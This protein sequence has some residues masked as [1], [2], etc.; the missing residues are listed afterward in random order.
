MGVRHEKMHRARSGRVLG[1]FH[2]LPGTRD[3]GQAHSLLY[4]KLHT[5]G[6]HVVEK[7]KQESHTVK[8]ELLSK[9]KIPYGMGLFFNLK[10]Y[11]F[12]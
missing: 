3:K 12:T 7:V 11:V 8:T 9:T 5:L 10:F 1:S 2:A 6:Y 4:K